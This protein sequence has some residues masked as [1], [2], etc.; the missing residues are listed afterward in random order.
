M[1]LS[2]VASYHSSSLAFIALKLRKV[3]LDLNLLEDVLLYL[4]FQLFSALVAR[5]QEFIISILHI[6]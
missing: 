4:N 6:I 3:D 5:L 2:A 1:A